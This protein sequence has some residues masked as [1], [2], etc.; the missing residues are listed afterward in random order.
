[1][2]EHQHRNRDKR[3]DQQRG[4]RP[5][6]A[7]EQVSSQRG[8]RAVGVDAAPVAADEAGSW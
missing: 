1:M 4:E 8:H 5:E 3:D 6:P 2:T 7:L